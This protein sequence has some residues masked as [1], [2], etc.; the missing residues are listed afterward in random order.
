MKYNEIPC[1]TMCSICIPQADDP[2]KTISPA[3][4]HG[5]GT[6]FPL[7]ATGAP[8]LQNFGRPCS[9]TARERKNH[10]EPSSVRG[11]WWEEMDFH[12]YAWLRESAELW[13]HSPVFFLQRCPYKESLE[14]RYS[15]AMHSLACRELLGQGASNAFWAARVAR[16]FDERLS[17]WHPGGVPFWLGHLIHCENLD[18]GIQCHFFCCEEII[19]RLFFNLM[20]MSNVVKVLYCLWFRPHAPCEKCSPKQY[21]HT[22]GF[23]GKG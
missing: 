3:R 10:G 23:Y 12:W 6:H 22:L 5:G 13:H 2:R 20:M 16:K 8:R 9:L 11:K 21:G 18:E 4:Q 7:H 19:L 15:I 1:N 17:Q 14:T